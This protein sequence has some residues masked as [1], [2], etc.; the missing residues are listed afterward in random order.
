MVI[1]SLILILFIRGEFNILNKI[2]G[3]KENIQNVFYANALLYHIRSDH[4]WKMSFRAF[5]GQKWASSK[6]RVTKLFTYIG[7]AVTIYAGYN[8]YRAN[9]EEAHLYPNAILYVNLNKYTMSDGAPNKFDFIQSFVGGKDLKNIQDVI[10][11]LKIATDDPHIHG[12][13]ANLSR[14]TS[15]NLSQAQELSQAIKEFTQKG[16]KASIAY[17]DTF[18]KRRIASL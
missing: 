14:L 1:L 10:D 15:M 6:R 17:S 9:F 11:G 13:V 4:L 16:K 7:G 18:G 12:L 3:E 5:I 2:M 8:V